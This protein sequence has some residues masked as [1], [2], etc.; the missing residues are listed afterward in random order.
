MA[1]TGMSETTLSWAGRT[2]FVAVLIAVIAFFW[3]LL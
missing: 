2:L 1:K 3:W